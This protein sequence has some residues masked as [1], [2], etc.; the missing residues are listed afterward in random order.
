MRILCEGGRMPR[1]LGGLF[2]KLSD[3]VTLDLGLC[4]PQ[5]IRHVMRFFHRISL[6]PLIFSL[7]KNSLHTILLQITYNFKQKPIF[8]LKKLL[9]FCVPL[10]IK[11]PLDY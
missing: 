4:S 5:K 7:K 10:E 6:I 1:I 2:L 11:R 9:E 8:I 3:K